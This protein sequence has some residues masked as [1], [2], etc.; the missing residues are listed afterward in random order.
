MLETA[1][2]DVQGAPDSGTRH[3]LREGRPLCYTGFLR[4][5]VA[6]ADLVIVVTAPVKL[7][8]FLSRRSRRFARGWRRLAVQ[9]T[10]TEFVYKKSAK[11]KKDA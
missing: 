7:S 1:R 2:V 11:T 8:S 9:M 3:C 5:E 10:D 6:G 4:R